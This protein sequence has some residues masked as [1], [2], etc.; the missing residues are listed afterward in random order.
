VTDDLNQI[1]DTARERNAPMD[2]IVWA[3]NPKHDTIESSRPIW[4]NMIR[5]SRRCGIRCRL[6]LSAK[7]PRTGLTTE[8]RHNL[9]LAYKEALHNAV[10]HAGATEVCITIAF[11]AK[12]LELVVE[13]NARV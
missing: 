5:L 2:E 10:K 13:D 7:L 8:V 4:K 1:Y 12:T 9:F 11:E 6:D 3:V